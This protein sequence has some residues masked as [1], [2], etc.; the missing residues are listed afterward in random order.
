MRGAGELLITPEHEAPL[1]ATAPTSVT[2]KA[3]LQNRFRKDTPD[4]KQRW[5]LQARPRCRPCCWWKSCE[6]L[7]LGAKSSAVS[8]YPAH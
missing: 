4:S 5:K 7:V 6:R 1:S 8:I 2:A 3:R